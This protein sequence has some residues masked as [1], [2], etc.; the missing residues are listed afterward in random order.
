MDGRE[1]RVK[2]PYK[3][4]KSKANLSLART[5]THT[6]TQ[7]RDTMNKLNYTRQMMTNYGIP[8]KINRISSAP[9]YE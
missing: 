7:P 6:R 3:G 4:V 5:H 8:N 2:V 9:K 1:R